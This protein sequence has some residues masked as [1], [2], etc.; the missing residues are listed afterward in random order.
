MLSKKGFYLFALT[1]FCPNKI[2]VGSRD[3]SNHDDSRTTFQSSAV[4]SAAVLDFEFE[5]GTHHLAPASDV[6]KV[7]K[8]PSGA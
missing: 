3:I 8:T 4:P 1:S 2:P 5:N 7:K 6:S